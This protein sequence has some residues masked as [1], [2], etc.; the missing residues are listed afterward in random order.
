MIKNLPF[1]LFLLVICCSTNTESD[2]DQRKID[3][4]KAF[5]K[6]YG[7]V[8]YF[9]PS[10][11]AAALD[12]K[13]FSIYGAD[14]VKECKSDDEL[15]EALNSLFLPIAPSIR[16]TRDLTASKYDLA[17]ITPKNIEG[18]KPAFWQHS[19]VSKGM[20]S[21]FYPQNPYRSVRVNGTIEHDYS[22]KPSKLMFSIDPTEYRGKKIKYSAWAKFGDNIPEKGYLRLVVDSSDGTADLKSEPVVDNQ[23]KRY[24][25]ITTVDTL[26]TSITIGATLQGK[27]SLFF[28]KVNLSFQHDNKWIEVPVANHNF[29]S[30]TLTESEQPDNW[31]YDGLGYSFSILSSDS[32][33]G[34]SCVLMRYTGVDEVERGQPIFDY[35]PQFGELIEKP[36]TESISC[37]IPLV[38]YSGE[39]GTFPRVDS[40]RLS[41]LMNHLNIGAEEPHKGSPNVSWDTKLNIRYNPGDVSVRLGNVINTYNVFQHFFP[42]MEVVDV[43]WDQELEKAISS[44]L[45]DKTG[46]DH[47]ITLQKFTA[48][49]KDGHITV[50][51][52]GYRD[53]S[54]PGITWEWIEGKLVITNVVDSKIPLGKG[55][56][57]EQIDGM[58]ARDYFKE[59]E[60]RVSAGTTGYLNHKAESMGLLG[61]KNTE[62]IITVNDKK[63][64][65]VRDSYPYSTGISNPDF[66]RIN[67]SVVY[68]NINKIS[69]DSIDSSLPELEKAKSIICDLR[70]YPNGNQGFLS[71]LLKENDTTASWMQIPKN[72]YP[73]QEHLIGYEDGSWHLPARKPYLGDKRII[74]LV[75]GSAISYAESYMGYVQGYD[76]ATI[77]GEPTAG[78]NGNINPFELP[79]GYQIVWTGMKVTKQDGSQLFGVGF[80]PDVL[81][82]KT[83][84]G[85]KEGRDEFLEKAIEL[86]DQ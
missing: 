76:L 17:I 48:S 50:S 52:K 1:I 61:E 26:A 20:Q 23:W 86:A 75:Q 8:K 59:I 16:F 34:K 84:K 66:K 62:M 38:L 54:S 33:Q 39:N 36:V 57:V 22:Q 10:D 58:T 2:I 41:K 83:I 71:Y 72:V 21:D 60:S 68:L 69:M 3:N 78:T 4:L 40:L 43:D 25:I 15:V 64:T 85:I 74:F 28:D 14:R 19:G 5:A 81:V 80:I 6:V 29:E 56:M 9:H 32:Y 49:L 53:F 7:Y 46:K 51:Y 18:Y 24:E 12:W 55:D 44:S 47:L 82:H 67:D 73:D 35:A 27:D 79:G 77:I 42:Y 11:E 37:Q 31:F 45:T 65:L 13:A 63:I 30:G 70:Y